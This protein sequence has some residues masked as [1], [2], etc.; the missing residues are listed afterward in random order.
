RPKEGERWEVEVNTGLEGWLSRIAGSMGRGYLLTIDYGEPGETLYGPE[1][2]N[3]T[4]RGFSG[5][6]HADDLLASPGSIDL[7]ASID[8]TLLS[9]TAEKLGLISAPFINQHNFL[10]AHG[11][12]EE[13]ARLE[14]EIGDEMDLLAFRRSMGELI[15]P[16]QGMGESFMAL[17]QAKNAPLEPLIP[18]PNRTF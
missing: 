2:P 10:F 15:F 16:G 6:R 4:I 8:F 7:T 1:R 12:L 17:V 3:G 14:G 11:L 5:H 9:K 13:A 18:P